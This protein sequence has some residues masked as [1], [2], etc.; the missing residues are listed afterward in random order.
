MKRSTTPSQPEPDWVWIAGFL[1]D[2]MRAAKHPRTKKRWLNGLIN[3]AEVK[4]S[5]KRRYPK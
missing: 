5:W 1:S 2:K 4:K 3:M